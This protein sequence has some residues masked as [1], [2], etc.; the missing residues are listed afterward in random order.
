MRTDRRT[1]ITRLIIG[2]GN[3]TN[4]PK[5]YLQPNLQRPT[6]AQMKACGQTFSTIPYFGLPPPIAVNIHWPWN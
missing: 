1:D 5:N 4:A 3:I 6:L 2:F